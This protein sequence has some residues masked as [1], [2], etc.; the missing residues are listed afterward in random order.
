MNQRRRNKSLCEKSTEIAINITKLSS[1]YLARIM[2][3]PKGPAKGVQAHTNAPATV[4]IE[5][6]KSKR[7][8]ESESGLASKYVMKPD[9]VGKVDNQASQ[10]IRRI[11]EK[12]YYQSDP[13]IHKEASK[14]I[15][16]PPKVKWASNRYR[17]YS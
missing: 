2:L 15:P 14:C 6:S 8:A 7:M 16:P 13:D 9:E 12:N 4:S 1:L 5:D 11:K 10:F 17:H 3:G